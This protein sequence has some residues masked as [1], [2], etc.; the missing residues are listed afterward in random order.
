MADNIHYEAV[1]GSVCY[2][3][4]T[5]TSDFDV[6]GFCIPPKHM[7]FPHLA[8]EIMG[9]GK[10][11]QRFNVY[12]Q[13]HVKDESAAA[14]K[15]RMY[16][17]TVYSIVSYFQL[18]MDN[19]PNMLDSL[20]APTDCVL[21]CTKIGNMI[22]DRRRDFLHKGAWHRFKGYAYSQ[23][24][25]MQGKNV[26]P[27]SKRDQLRQQYGFDVKFAYHT[28][29]LLFEVE[30][31]LTEGDLDL[32][33]NS[34]QLKA[35]RRGDLAEEEVRRIALD[36]EHALERI[37]EASTLRHSPDEAA[38]KQLLLDCLEE[39]WG[40]LQNFTDTAIVTE[41]A[42]VKALEEIAEI[43]SRFRRSK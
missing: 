30:Q 3:V 12:Q 7:V 25:K 14:G 41:D 36:K 40:S 28:I 26:E 5:D 19:N 11:H 38:I 34:E 31:I 35:I 2:G 32:R 13:H 4:S 21:H 10:Q 33:R 16:D 37:Y 27:G 8:G 24:H 43:A 15:G 6:V 39:H 42:P 1:M 17:I 9:F 23:L 29:R 20:F 22:R 18:C